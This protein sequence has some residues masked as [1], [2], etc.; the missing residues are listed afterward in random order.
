MQSSLSQQPRG[1]AAHIFRDAPTIQKPSNPT[2]GWPA[3]LG[4]YSDKQLHHNKT[5]TAFIKFINVAC[6]GMGFV[7][8]GVFPKKSQSPKLKQEVKEISWLRAH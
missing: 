5:L 1:K 7:V 8:V 3:L 6:S 4:F 2:T